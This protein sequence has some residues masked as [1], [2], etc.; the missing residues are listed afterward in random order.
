MDPW[1]NFKWGVFC[2][3]W[4]GEFLSGGNW[5]EIGKICLPPPSTSNISRKIAPSRKMWEILNE[6]QN[7]KKEADSIKYL[8]TLRFKGNYLLACSKPN[9]YVKRRCDMKDGSSTKCVTNA[10]ESISSKEG[11]FSSTFCFQCLFFVL[12]GFNC[13]YNETI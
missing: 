10:Q 11:N 13:G 12:T 5:G 2:F 4:E 3:E 1:K 8:K 9:L 6:G 7:L